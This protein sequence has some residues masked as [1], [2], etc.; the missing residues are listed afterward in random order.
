MKRTFLHEALVGILALSLVNCAKED[1]SMTTDKDPTSIEGNGLGEGNGRDEDSLC[2]INKE[3]IKYTS[4][5]YISST[6]SKPIELWTA[7]QFAALAGN[8]DA[9]VGHLALCRDI[10]FAGW[11]SSHPFFKIGEFSTKPFVGSLNGRKKAI[12]NFRYEVEYTG[13]GPTYGIIHTGHGIFGMAKGAS[14]HDIKVIDATLHFKTNGSANIQ[15]AGSLLGYGDSVLLSNILALRANVEVTGSGIS[16]GGLVG[17][18]QNSKASHVEVRDSSVKGTAIINGI[19]SAL[20][21][22]TYSLSKNNQVLST[23][24]GTS[25]QAISGIGYVQKISWSKAQDNTVAGYRYVSGAGEGS[26]M[27]NVLVTGG[28][29]SGVKYVGGL[30]SQMYCDEGVINP[31]RNTYTNVS[32]SGM[33]AVGGHIGLY[34]YEQPANNQSCDEPREH[35][36]FTTSQVKENGV[37]KP[38]YIGTFNGNGVDKTAFY[39]DPQAF[40][41]DPSAVSIQSADYFKNANNAPMNT[42]EFAADKWVMTNGTLDIPS[43]GYQN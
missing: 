17:I 21:E 12:R 7:K 23:G 37:S 1:L 2:R 29:V 11:Y 13:V 38:A 39:F 30:I 42:W 35:Q 20:N 3:T 28:T 4:A 31:I 34:G 14:F 27:Q 22:I 8:D 16:I 19:G 25:S 18:A 5:D 43:A 24:T 26:E 41:M 32:V 10:E 33:E 9:L 40:G 6:P 15:A 36:S